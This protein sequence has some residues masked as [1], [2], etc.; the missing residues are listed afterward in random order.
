LSTTSIGAGN[1]EI[2]LDGEKV[3]LRPTLRAAQTISKQNGGIMSA[4]QAV[5]NF[6]FETITSVI[7]LGLNLTGSVRVNEVAEKV[8]T[9]GLVD[10][11]EPVTKYLTVLANGGRST[12]AKGGEEEQDPQ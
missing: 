4:V 1:I 7:A 3:V 10:L 5:A 11:V 8:Y 9:T 2:T 12:E 6:D